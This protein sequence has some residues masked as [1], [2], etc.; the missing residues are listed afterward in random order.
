MN[1]LRTFRLVRAHVSTRMMFA[2]LEHFVTAH[3]PCLE[4]T[5]DVGEL[6]DAGYRMPSSAGAAWR[7]IDES[8]R[9]PRTETCSGR[10]CWRSATSAPV[11]SHTKFMLVP[12][13]FLWLKRRH[14]LAI[15][16]GL[17]V[18]GVLVGCAMSP[19]ERQAAEQAWAARD[20]E[21]ANRGG[22]GP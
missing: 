14:S 19:A 13:G 15:L 4:L 12:L 22:G 2:E 17:L 21:R 3:R 11:D 9:T 16:L 8:R 18:G 10:G 1:E 5:S 7:S 20:A 6:T